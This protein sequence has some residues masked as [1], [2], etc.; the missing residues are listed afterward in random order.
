MNGDGEPAPA[1]AA[2]LLNW[3]ASERPR[4]YYL[5]GENKFSLYFKNYSTN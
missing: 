2:P 3:K 4:I 5:S 1:A